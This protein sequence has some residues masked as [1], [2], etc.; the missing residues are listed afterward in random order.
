LSKLEKILKVR[1]RASRFKNMLS[2][3]RQV[4]QITL[5]Q[6][7]SDRASS[8]VQAIQTISPTISENSRIDRLLVCKEGFPRDNYV[9]Q[10]SF[11]NKF[12]KHNIKDTLKAQK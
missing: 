1:R 4:D 9:S 3:E 12:L 5:L 10:I 2:R 7:K 6:I 11:L 8:T